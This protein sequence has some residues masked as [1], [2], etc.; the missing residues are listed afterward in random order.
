MPLQLVGMLPACMPPEEWQACVI[1]YN[2]DLATQ[3]HTAHRSCRPITSS[4]LALPRMQHSVLAN[5]SLTSDGA[6][7]VTMR[8][9]IDVEGLPASVC[10]HL[11]ACCMPR[12]TSS[13]PSDWSTQQAAFLDNGIMWG[14]V[15]VR[16]NGCCA[17]V[18]N[19]RS[20]C[21]LRILMK[22]ALGPSR[23]PQ[24]KG[25]DIAEASD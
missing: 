7:Y 8:D 23:I 1:N 19:G 6:L 20:L 13:A 21:W 24:Q 25:Q 17:L 15:Y 22:G 9:Q 11:S 4:F 16:C 10:A 14:G 3:P 5:Y 2:I 12:T 18:D